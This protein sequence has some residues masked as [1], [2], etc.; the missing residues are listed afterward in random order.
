[1]EM[2]VEESSTASKVAVPNKCLTFEFCVSQL[3]AVMVV[4]LMGLWGSSL[5]MGLGGYT[6][7]GESY[8]DNN[9]HA[10][11]MVIG[12]VVLFGE[13]AIVFRS[14]T[15]IS[16]YKAKVLHSI[17]LTAG[18]LCIIAGMTVVIT[19]YNKKNMTHFHSIHSWC[20]LV[21]IV[22][23]TLQLLLGFLVFMWPVG[24]PQSL[25][26][27][28]HKIH[29]FCG[30]LIWS[31]VMASCL[32]GINE[33]LIYKGNN[34]KYKANSY[35]TMEPMFVVGNILGLTIILYTMVVKWITN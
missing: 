34:G 18:F 17:L 35:Q 1:M 28:Y 21:T 6:W 19:L 3:L 10:L 20:G 4:V 12:M 14:F 31:L 13:A 16:K 15:C 26:K 23:F 27:N 2:Q 9:T 7:G 5:D 32:T 11:L 22:M 33:K 24:I 29:L 30:S 8:N 25:K